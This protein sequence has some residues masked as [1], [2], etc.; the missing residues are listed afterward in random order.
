[1]NIFD[2]YRRRLKTTTCR[3]CGGLLLNQQIEY[4]EHS[5]GWRVEGHVAKQWLYIECP[6]CKYQWSLAKL[7]VPQKEE[8]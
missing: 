3:W 7:G 6:G 2:E 8:V 4:Y 5:G 1:M